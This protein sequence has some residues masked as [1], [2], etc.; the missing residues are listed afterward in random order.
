MDTKR[1]KVQPNSNSKKTFEIQR[2]TKA[3]SLVRIM[4]QNV[5]TN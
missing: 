1:A 3:P 4:E 5:Q 2:N